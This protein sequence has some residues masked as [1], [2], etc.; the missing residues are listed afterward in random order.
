MSLFCLH[1]W[2]V[3]SYVKALNLREGLKKCQKCQSIKGFRRFVPL[4]LDQVD[5][6]EVI[7]ITPKITITNFLVSL[8]ATLIV[9]MVYTSSVYPILLKELHNIPLNPISNTVLK[10]M[11]AMPPIMLTI[12]LIVRGIEL[13]RGEAQDNMENPE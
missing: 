9:I 3:P 1:E 10:I 4:E 6:D 8:F 7:I 13:I 12:F 11:L 5:S 2:E